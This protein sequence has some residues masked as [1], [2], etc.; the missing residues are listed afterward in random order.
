MCGPPEISKLDKT[1]RRMMHPVDFSIQG[2][3]VAPNLEG[4]E[5][6]LR[7]LN[8]L[9]AA[10]KRFY[11]KFKV[12]LGSVNLPLFHECDLQKCHANVLL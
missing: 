1:I 9:Q 5:E 8:D 11:P 3:N 12:Q 7:Y 4:V 10:G 2:S 6:R